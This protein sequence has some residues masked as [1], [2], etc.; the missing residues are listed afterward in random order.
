MQTLVLVAHPHLA[1][2]TT[3]QF[4]KASLPATGVTYES[5]DAQE[6]YAVDREQAALRQADRIIL[7]FP[8]YWY[9]APASLARWE[10]AVLTRTFVYGDRRYPLADKELG[11]VVTTGMPAQAFR[12][13]GL[14]NVTIDTLM[15]PLA[16]LAHRA[17]MT[18]LPTMAVHQFNYLDETQKLQLV[19]AYQRYLTQSAPDTLANRQAWFAARLPAMVA[20]LAPKDRAIGKLITATLTQQADELEA[21]MATLAM[22]KEQDDD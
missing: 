7:Q 12:R 6:T 14:E 20:K 5:L 3:Q 11:V 9:A 15:A 1:D 13:G 18:W 10:A 4:F 21:L 22:I 8:L 2:S 19:V 17:H 16:A